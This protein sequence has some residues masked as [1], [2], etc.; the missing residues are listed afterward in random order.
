MPQAKKNH[1]TSAKNKVK[2]EATSAEQPTIS[3]NPPNLPNNQE[4]DEEPSE[5]SQKFPFFSKG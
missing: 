4:E 1:Q 2:A 3:E 5:V